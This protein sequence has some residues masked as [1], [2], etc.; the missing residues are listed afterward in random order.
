MG[1]R[2]CT[3]GVPRFCHD[4]LV[5]GSSWTELDV[6]GMHKAT[7]AAL[8][9][10]TGRFVQIHPDDHSKLGDL[11]LELKGGRLVERPATAKPAAPPP[12]FDT[13]D[14]ETVDDRPAGRRTGKR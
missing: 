10:H 13:S 7:R 9:E 14:S 6:E 8:V 4:G 5:V 3:I 2:V 12:A 1:I 11:G